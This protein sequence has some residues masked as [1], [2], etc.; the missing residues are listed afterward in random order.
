MYQGAA[1]KQQGY[2]SRYHNGEK[3]RKICAGW[4]R[5]IKGTPDPV[6]DDLIGPR[7]KE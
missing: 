3:K 6:V 7:L 2:L 1:S 4:G 5:G